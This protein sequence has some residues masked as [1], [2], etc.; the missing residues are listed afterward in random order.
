MGRKGWVGGLVTRHG[1][2]W[3]LLSEG[4]YSTRL[5]EF[6]QSVSIHI[7]HALS[8]TLYIYRHWTIVEARCNIKPTKEMHKFFSKRHQSGYKLIVLTQKRNAISGGGK[9]GNRTHSV[10]TCLPGQNR[11]KTFLQNWHALGPRPTCAHNSIMSLHHFLRS[12]KT[13]LNNSHTNTHQSLR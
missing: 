13:K 11:I 9:K 6:M 1:S 12:S 2:R 3:A 5:S 7:C 8:V 10:R 4:F